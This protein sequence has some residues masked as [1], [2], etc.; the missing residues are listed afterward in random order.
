MVV[1]VLSKMV[2]LRVPFLLPP[3][4]SVQVVEPVVQP[5]RVY[6]GMVLQ[7]APELAVKRIASGCATVI[8]Q[9]EPDCLVPFNVQVFEF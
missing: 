8:L 3:V 5:V 6:C 4:V 9:P 7:V 2:T 1:V